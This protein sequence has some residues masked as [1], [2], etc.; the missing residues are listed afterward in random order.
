MLCC[1]TLSSVYLSRTN[2][3]SWGAILSVVKHV[4]SVFVQRLRG[5][6]DSWLQ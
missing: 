2:F 3:S 1:W 6:G 5:V 4:L